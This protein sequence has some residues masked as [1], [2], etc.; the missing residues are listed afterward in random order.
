LNALLA[1][2]HSHW[3]ELRASLSAL[4]A[5]DAP[6]RWELLVA[7]SDVE[8]LLPAEVG[9]YSDAYASIY[10]A[11]NV[12]R[13]F[14]PD[15]P[16]LPNYKYVPIS[17]HGRASSLVISGTPVRRPQ[18]Q[19]QSSDAAPVFAPSA[20][21]DYELEIGALIGP[22]TALGNPLTIGQAAEHI[23]GLCLV[24]DW[25]A[26]DMQRWEYQPLGPFLSKSFATTLSPWVVTLDAL[27]PFRTAAFQRPAGDPPPLPYLYDERDQAEGGFAITVE[28]YLCSTQMRENGS[29]PLRLSHGS[30]SDM[31]WTLAQLVTHQASNGCNLRPGDLIA[32]GTISGPEPG[33][34]GCLLE[35]TQGGRAPLELPDGEQRSALHDGDEIALRAYCERDGLAR[36][37]FGACVG[38]VTR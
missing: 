36:I 23:F 9:D 17:Y 2:G 15:N 11:T 32:S 28:A 30:F 5:A 16:L 20:N 26:R 27:A 22:G 35:I 7:Q 29:P 13:L 31:Y 25:S 34:F 14:R 37:G 24:N 18:G 33:S 10:H 4:L 19:R 21:L 12:G 3:R 6:P 38:V 1:L 8:L